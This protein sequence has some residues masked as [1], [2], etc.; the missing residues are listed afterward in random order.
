MAKS[1][2]KDKENSFRDSLLGKEIPVLTLDNKW[3][4]LL[5]EVGRENVKPLELQLNEL[6]K[7]Q[8]KINSETKEIKK[9]KKRYM[10]EI[11]T[12]V[13]A[14]SNGDASAEK[15]VAD[16]KRIVEDCNRKLEEYEDE[17]VD[18]PR[19]I[20]EVNRK[21]MLVTMEH[22]YETM[23]DNTDDIEE[24]DEWLTSVRIELKKNLIRKQ[25]KEAK[26]HQIYSY[27]HDIF[28]PEVVELFDLRYNP[29]EHHPMTKA[30]L[31]KKKENEQPPNT[32]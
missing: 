10:E 14:A 11:V 19:E 5:G 16:N 8:G 17:I 7:R 23:Q 3:Y 32:N 1:S 9:I 24:L 6:L 18:I 2:G 28:G 12:L 31:E 13:D 26:N 29:E 15:K 21:L 4:K 22:C 30:E 27:M 25:E 20:N